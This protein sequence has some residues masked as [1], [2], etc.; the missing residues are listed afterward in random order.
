VWAQIKP[1][2]Q[3]AAPRQVPLSVLAVVGIILSGLVHLALML[4]IINAALKPRTIQVSTP[5]Q[6]EVVEAPKPPPPPPPPP[7]V[8][9]PKKEPPKVAKFKP[10]PPPKDAPPP[11]P[12]PPEEA[13]PPPPNE[14]P[15]PDAKPAPVMIGLTMSSTS[16]AGGFAAPVGNTLYGT[17]PRVAPKPE[18]VK[19]YAPPPP[20]GRVVAPFKV[21]RLP[22]V[23][24]DFKADYPPEARKLG[25]E[26]QVVLRLTV[27]A[28]GKVV[29][30]TILKGAGNGF[31]EAALG[32]VKKF[33]FKPG[34]EG[35]EAVTT[36][37]TYTY[38]FLLD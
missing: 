2:P 14:P 15:P 17:A 23:M 6:L 10:P 20:G 19:P 13:P 8:E 25:I 7:K 33:R 28:L 9:E 27:D 31:D 4:I 38:T 3:L 18:D 16:S 29:K 34:Y 11:P 30:A 35:D 37:L 24:S 1:F 36:D 12:K 21:T 5:V 26:G 32:A 22:E